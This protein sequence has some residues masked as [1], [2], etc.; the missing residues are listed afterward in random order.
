MDRLSPREC[1]IVQLV[2]EGQSVSD[3]ARRLRLSVRSVE[4]TLET[5]YSKLGIG[6]PLERKTR[7]TPR[8]S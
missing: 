5:V 3:I 8:F 1:E 4:S 2:S 7:P 6:M